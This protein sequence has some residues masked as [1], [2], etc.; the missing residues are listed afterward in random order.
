MICHQIIDHIPHESVN[1]VP[2]VEHATPRSV[3]ECDQWYWHRSCSIPQIQDAIDYSQIWSVID[4]VSS[5]SRDRHRW[6]R[7]LIRLVLG[8]V[9]DRLD[10]RRSFGGLVL[11]GLFGG[12]DLRR[13]F[14]GLDLGHAL[15]RLDL[16]HTLIGLD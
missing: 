5:A 6:D 9:F 16:G 13:S 11:G 10:S 2:C 14:G 7:S 15:I 3:L 8:R 4:G 12:M 1:R